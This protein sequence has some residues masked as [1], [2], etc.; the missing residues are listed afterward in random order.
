MDFLWQLLSVRSQQLNSL[1]K[2]LE[3]LICGGLTI[4]HSHEVTHALNQ[5]VIIS[6]LHL[7]GET[8]VSCLDEVT[9]ILE[10]RKGEK[11]K[12]NSSIHIER[13]YACF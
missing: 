6:L 7:F 3:H 5:A 11:V 9:K 8:F 1:L 12:R 13:I 2:G 4:L 10:A